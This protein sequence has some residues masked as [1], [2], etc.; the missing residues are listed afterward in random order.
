MRGC[1]IS[2][3]TARSTVPP[4][5]SLGAA[6]LRRHIQ[7]QKQELQAEIAMMQSD[8]RLVQT[9]AAFKRWL[10]KQHVLA[11]DEDRFGLPF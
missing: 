11:Q 9:D 3:R 10:R 4:Y 1:S 5:V 6:A 8:L 2:P 7:E